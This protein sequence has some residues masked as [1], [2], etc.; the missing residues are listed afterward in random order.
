MAVSWMR[1]FSEFEFEN[2]WLG[3]VQLPYSFLIFFFLKFLGF[4][5]G[6]GARKKIK[7]LE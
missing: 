2:K 6:F 5:D 1:D 3:R 4:S 7:I